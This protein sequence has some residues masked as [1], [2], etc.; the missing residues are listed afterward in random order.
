MV[1]TQDIESYLFRPSQVPAT[2]GP[3]HG[4]QFGFVHF[5]YPQRLSAES[6][7]ASII[8]LLRLR[9]NFFALVQKVK[10]FGKYHHR[11]LFRLVRESRLAASLNAFAEAAR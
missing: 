9:M 7:D 6:P 4:Y 5:T 3:V 11:F 1:L 8:S 10:V 2:Q